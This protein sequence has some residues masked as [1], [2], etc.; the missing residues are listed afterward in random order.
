MSVN[1]WDPNWLCCSWVRLALEVKVDRVSMRAP[2]ETRE[3]LRANVQRA[4]LTVPPS[5]WAS[6]RSLSTLEHKERP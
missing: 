2:Q 5:P 3:T 6:A 1:R 4:L